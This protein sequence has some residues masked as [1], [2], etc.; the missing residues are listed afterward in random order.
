MAAR[1][2]IEI[3]G[4]DK[5]GNSQLQQTIGLLEQLMEMRTG[6][7]FDL[8]KADTVDDLRAVGEQLTG[9]NI[10]IAEY[11]NMAS[12]AT[13]A[14]KDNRTAVILDNLATKVSLARANT[15]AFGESVRVQSAEL[16][17]YQS[18][19]DQ[20]INN[21]L[22]RTSTEVMALESNIKRLTGSISAQK[23]IVA[24]QKAYDALSNKL[25]EISADTRLSANAQKSAEASM[26]A[27]QSAITALIR[28]GVDP[29]DNK[30]KTLQ[31][32][33][34][35]LNQQL[36]SASANAIIGQFQQTGSIINDLNGRISQLKSQL[37]FATSEDSIASL[38]RELADA[39]KELKRLQTIG[40]S[41]DQLMQRFSASS[42]SVGTE[43][44]R[45]VQDLPYTSRA[46]GAMQ[47]NFGAIGNNI[48]RLGE[49]LPQYIANIRASAAANGQAATS[50]TVLKNALLGLVSGANGFIFA[51]SLLTSAYT[52]YQA[53]SQKRQRE[54]AKEKKAEE[55]Y[56]E[57]IR[58]K[59]SL[60]KAVTQA[61]NTGQQDAVAETTRIN[62]LRQAI[63]SELVPRRNRLN[64]I[65]ELRQTYPEYFKNLK[66]EALLAGQAAEVY[67]K[68]AD[69]LMKTAL[70]QA[71][72][73]KAT[74]LGR[75]L[76]DI[77]TERFNNLRKI[78][79][80]ENKI[81]RN[82]AEQLALNKA[83]SKEVRAAGNAG[84]GSGQ[85]LSGNEQRYAQ[86]NQENRD[87]S[88]E[89]AEANAANARA[90]Q[91]DS[92]LKKEINDL[93]KYTLDLQIQGADITKITA[94][95]TER[96]VRAAKE[97]GSA[98]ADIYRPD[99]DRGN[100]V[101]LDGL[102]KTNQA[103]QNRYAELIRELEKKEKEFSAT[104]KKE[105]AN[106]T[107]SAS[108]A[109]EKQK[110]L[111]REVANERKEINEGLDRELRAN[112]QKFIDDRVNI[113]AQAEERA[114]KA[115]VQSRQS[116]LAAE[117]AYWDS[118]TEQLRRYGVTAEQ[119]AEFRKSAEA[120]INKKW[121][122]KMVEESFIFQRRENESRTQLLIRRLNRE[123]ALELQA[124]EGNVQKKIALQKKYFEQ[125]NAI[126]ARDQEV[127]FLVN[128]DFDVFS[129]QLADM[130]T[131]AELF[132][133]A[134]RNNVITTDQFTQAM[135]RLQM[136]TEQ[137]DVM[138]QG[139]DSLTSAVGDSFT[140]ALFGAENVLENLGESFKK[141][142]QDIISGLIKIALRYAIN[143]ALGTAS[144]AA[145]AA[146]SRGAAA[147]VA[148]A[149]ATAAALVSA[150]TFGANTA[151]AGVSLA[152]LVASSKAL[153]GF[154]SGGYTGNVSRRDVAGVVHGQEYV[155]NAAATK[156]YM[157]LLRT[158][159]S[160]GDISSALPKS[161]GNVNFGSVSSQPATE[162]IVKI[163]G[164]LSNTSIKLSNDRAQR[165]ERKFGRG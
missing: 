74:E 51:L 123:T 105:V 75:Q 151:A 7:N 88:K 27:Y 161:V 67:Q 21:G 11:L 79:D 5:G 59:I 1:L 120:Q 14:F 4:S 125:L 90:S 106:R 10:R 58:K 147:A 135:M 103:T 33:I 13:D 34:A 60:M 94:D 43:F 99:T 157:P 46:F 154:S 142:A 26:R 134:L 109:A 35:S 42:N 76:I 89:I 115:R 96:Q 158:I 165:F 54:L 81:T 141:V 95:N 152:A 159:N 47:D 85:A 48:T 25:K 83:I 129:I 138:R 37:N 91:E 62:A 144:M 40:L 130:A 133:Q 116:E 146:A 84:T 156:Q 41:A 140:G 28:S 102:N 136:Q 143:Q 30:I 29:A 119:I 104:Y 64:A 63:E 98:I 163:Q 72:V 24:E 82:Q 39:Q 117:R 107:I 92:K 118:R 114:G 132:G 22:D 45:I 70:A 12:K 66:N 162:Q 56:M 122:Q 73:Q 153:S 44:A 112:T 124:A 71:A 100:L 31:Q 9:V 113:L 49:L 57:T 53:V 19:F 23:N 139:F 61:S 111:E 87:A 97:L 160:G 68:L 3:G 52:I 8:I 69:N 145:S 131:K 2:E 148:S 155:I 16:R 32:S 149:W 15:Q 80:A 38:N 137:L 36:Q 20:L 121:D 6:L 93:T 127:D 128:A 55:D 77:N 126:Q 110:A 78:E 65:K 17:A 150:A 164:N 18:A 101:G 108:Q 50:A 86:L